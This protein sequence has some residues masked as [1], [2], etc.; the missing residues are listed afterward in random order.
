M[1]DSGVCLICF[2]LKELEE[3]WGKLSGA[4]GAPPRLL[5]SQQAQPP[6]VA[7]GG[8]ADGGG[9]G[10]GEERSSEGVAAAPVAIDPYDLADPEELLGKMP[11]DFF[12]KV[13]S[14]L[15]PLEIHFINSNMR[16]VCHKARLTAITDSLSCTYAVVL[17]IACH[18]YGPIYSDCGR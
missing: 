7:S 9:G 17:H 11:K 15:S 6:A 3:E 5:R 18:R 2:Q 1:I 14:Y 10:G 16:F 12:E 4:P 8:G 13:V